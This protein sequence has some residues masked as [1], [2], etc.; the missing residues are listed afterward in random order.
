[1]EQNH[2]CNFVRGHYG[3]HLFEI[4]LDL[5]QLKDLKIFLFLALVAILFGRAE[6]FMQFRGKGIM[7][8]IM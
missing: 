2:L 6:S 3:K 4:I 8:N 7:G 1:M 5:D